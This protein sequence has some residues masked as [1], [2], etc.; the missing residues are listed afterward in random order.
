[1]N[2]KSLSLLSPLN[3]VVHVH[4]CVLSTVGLL[5]DTT[6]QVFRCVIPRY[7]I[8][9]NVMLQSVTDSDI[10]KELP[11]TTIEDRVKAFNSLLGSSRIQLVGSDYDNPR[12][13]AF[14]REEAVKYVL[15]LHTIRFGAI[16]VVHR[17]VTRNIC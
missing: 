8:I 17:I 3:C 12:Y 1:M 10:A 7:F 15:L 9:G 16:Q 14:A 5:F 4:P 2:C 13:K 11:E 6:S